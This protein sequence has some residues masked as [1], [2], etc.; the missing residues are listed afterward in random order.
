MCQLKPLLCGALL[1]VAALTGG[2]YSRSTHNH[3][4]PG[5]GGD[6]GHAEEGRHGGALVEWGKH[7]YHPEFTVDHDKKQATVYI[8]GRDAKKPA[9]IKTE[10]ITVTI[11]NVKPPVTVT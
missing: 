6:H 7:E 9:P 11:K 10:S 2:C 1:A 4:K 8:L 3:G 5:A